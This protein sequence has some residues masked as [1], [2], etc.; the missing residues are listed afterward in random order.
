M[1]TNI[2]LPSLLASADR[3]TLA[4]V[5]THLAGDPNTVPDL[6]D[7]AQIEKVAAK[8]LPPYLAGEKTVDSPSEEVLQAA[9]N[10]AAGMEVPAEYG[11]LVRE[12]MG[13]GPAVESKPLKPPTGFKVVI[14][15]AGVS[16]SSQRSGSSSWDF[17]RSQFSRKI[18]SPVAPGGRIAI[19]AAASILRACCI[20]T[21]SRRI[22]DGRS[23]SAISRIS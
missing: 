22:P 21:R 15:G 4:A 12:Q 9:M 5:V 1:S 14:I 11:P 18:P 3:R 23:I 19:R 2:E 8:L 13:F 17:L 6:R 7:R 20:L 10:L 16:G